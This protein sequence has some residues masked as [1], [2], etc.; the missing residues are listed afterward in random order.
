MVARTRLNVTLYVQHIAC[1]VLQL[2]AQIGRPVRCVAKCRSGI[3]DMCVLTATNTS[4]KDRSTVALSWRDKPSLGCFL[5]ELYNSSD[6]DAAAV[7][8]PDKATHSGACFGRPR[9]VGLHCVRGA[10]NCWTEAAGSV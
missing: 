3:T 8:A 9:A 1:V 7:A 10:L 4:F 5:F 2:E 6:G